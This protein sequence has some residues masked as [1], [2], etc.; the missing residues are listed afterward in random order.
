MPS[1]YER[2]KGISGQHHNYKLISCS[3]PSI[4]IGQDFV[5]F[6]CFMFCLSENNDKLGRNGNQ[7]LHAIT[8]S[9]KF[10]KHSHWNVV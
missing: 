8:V 4:L 1:V 9:R 3:M 7:I 6:S 10:M 2:L 5:L